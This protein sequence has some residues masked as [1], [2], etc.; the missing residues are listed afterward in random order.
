MRSQ[1]SLIVSYL[2]D[3]FLFLWLLFRF[4]LALPGFTMTYV[5]VFSLKF[6]CLEF[7]S[8]VNLCLRIFIIFGKFLDMISDFFYLILFYLSLWVTSTHIWHLFTMIHFSTSPLNIFPFSSVFAVIILY[9]FVFHLINP[10]ISC[11]TVAVKT[12]IDFLI[13]CIIIFNSRMPK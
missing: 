12:S 7:C 11:N 10:L 5:G 1:C 8:S 4:S 2:K 6:S 9:Q 13:L 3:M